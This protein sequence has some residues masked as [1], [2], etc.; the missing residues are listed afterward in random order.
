MPPLPR[1]DLSHSLKGTA[2]SRPIVYQDPLHLSWRPVRRN[3]EESRPKGV[4]D[5]QRAQGLRRDPIRF[6]YQSEQNILHRFEGL[7]AF[8]RDVDRL[9]EG[10]SSR[11]GR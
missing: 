2:I 11:G 1:Y 8:L 10:S 6:R 5:S 7:A 4:R 9:F 3:V